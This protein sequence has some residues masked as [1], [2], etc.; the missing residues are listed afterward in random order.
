MASIMGGS[1]PLSVVAQALSFTLAS[2]DDETAD[3][4]RVSTAGKAGIAIGVAV[5][6]TLVI[7]IAAFLCTRRRR[8]RRILQLSISKPP[9]AEDSWEGKP[10]LSG[11]GYSVLKSDGEMHE[12][13]EGEIKE[14]GGTVPVYEL[15][16]PNAVHEMEPQREAE[17]A[18]TSNRRFS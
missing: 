12:A 17:P 14:L 11:E 6:A 18:H 4:S 13:A 5:L 2:N 16:A 3:V 8:R 9:L 15:E 10:E 1:G 7:L